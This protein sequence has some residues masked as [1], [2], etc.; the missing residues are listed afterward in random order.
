MRPTAFGYPVFRCLLGILHLKKSYSTEVINTACSYALDSGSVH[1]HAV[2]TFCESQ[3]KSVVDDLLEEHEV[4]RD[5]S[6]FGDILSDL[7][8]SGEWNDILDF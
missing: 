6:Y 1:Y 7:Q 3:G 2:K 4:I 5:L 8:N